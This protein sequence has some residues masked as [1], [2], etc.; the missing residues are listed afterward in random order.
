M[1]KIKFVPKYDDVRY[2]IK[3]NSPRVLS[4]AGRSRSGIFEVFSGPLRLARVAKIN[5]LEWG[6]FSE[7]SLKRFLLVLN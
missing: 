3:K 7:Q 1:P 2:F 6:V 4:V 5:E